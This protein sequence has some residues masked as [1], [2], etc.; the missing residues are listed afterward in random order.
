[1]LSHSQAENDELRLQEIQDRAAIQKLLSQG[2]GPAPGR[3][4]AG[5]APAPSTDHLLLKI[6]SLQAQLNEQ[7]SSAAC[8]PRDA[9]RVAATVVP[10]GMGDGWAWLTHS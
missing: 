4:Y 2:P 10:S 6:E 7:V 9:M 3:G 8:E 1:M 5:Q